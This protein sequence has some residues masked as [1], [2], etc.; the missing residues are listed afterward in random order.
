MLVVT[1]IS[2]IGC[3]KLPFDPFSD[4]LNRLE[5]LDIVV[6]HVSDRVNEPHGTSR[7]KIAPGK[8]ATGRG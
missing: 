5:Y 4:L 8:L 3:R 7:L 6:W 2:V 1:H